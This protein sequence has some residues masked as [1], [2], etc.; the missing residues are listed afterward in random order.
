MR[1]L[2]FRRAPEDPGVLVP[3]PLKALDR[4]AESGVIG[5]DDRRVLS[6]SYTWQWFVANRMALMGVRE[7]FR[8][9]RPDKDLERRLLLPGGLARTERMIRASREI[10]ARL[11]PP[12]SRRGRARSAGK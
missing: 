12:P 3:G 7:A 8:F 4:L 10:I 6:R 1:I 5:E 9:P 11:L 2:Q